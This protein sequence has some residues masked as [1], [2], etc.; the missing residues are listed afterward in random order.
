M[1]S[2]Q[3]YECINCG[4]KMVHARANQPAPGLVTVAKT[5]ADEL[6]QI[7]DGFMASIWP[8]DIFDEDHEIELV[9]R[10]Q[11]EAIITSERMK[12]GATAKV[13]LQLSEKVEALESENK[14][15]REALGPFANVAEHDIGNDEDD[16]DIFWPMSNAK[17]SISGRLRIGDLRRARAA[18]RERE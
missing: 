9:T 2:E 16:G 10:E 15:L 5:D 4:Q 7:I 17:Y 14:R 1:T 3:E 18:L 11:A 12:L 8:S 13:G 6:I